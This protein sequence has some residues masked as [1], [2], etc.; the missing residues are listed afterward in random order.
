MLSLALPSG[1]LAGNPAGTLD[2]TPASPPSGSS[3]EARDLLKKAGYRNEEVTFLEHLR[4][5]DFTPNPNQQLEVAA[6]T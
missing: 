4:W 6:S 2:S 1:A 3:S 5:L